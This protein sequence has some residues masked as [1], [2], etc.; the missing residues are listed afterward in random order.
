M[1]FTG[2]GLLRALS[3]K[4]FSSLNLKNKQKRK[5]EKHSTFESQQQIKTHTHDG[6][7]TLASHW[8]FGTY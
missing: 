7:A 1:N 8:I 3:H 6:R 5:K 2:G 4:A